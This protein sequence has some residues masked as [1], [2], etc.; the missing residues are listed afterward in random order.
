MTFYQIVQYLPNLSDEELRQL[1]EAIGREA[2]VREQRAM[3]DQ[4]NLTETQEGQNDF[5]NELIR[6]RGKGR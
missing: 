6:A 4:L 5:E 2:G 3:V 1:K